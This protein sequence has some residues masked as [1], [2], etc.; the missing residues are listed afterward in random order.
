MKLA[1]LNPKLE[2]SLADGVLRFD[3]PYPN[4]SHKIRVAVSNDGRNGTWKAEGE[5][6]DSLTLSPSINANTEG[7]DHEHIECWHGYIKVGEIQ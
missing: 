2:G 5:F 3:C 4:H 7:R 6:P 1:D